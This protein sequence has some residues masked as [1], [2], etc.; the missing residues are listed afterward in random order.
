MAKL[1]DGIKDYWEKQTPEQKRKLSIALVV[2]AVIACSTL[3]Y[4]LSHRKHGEQVVKSN[5]HK[6]EIVLD[7]GMMEESLYA[8]ATKGMDSTKKELEQTTDKVNT[9]DKRI[10]AM[11]SYVKGNAQALPGLAPVAAPGATPGTASGVGPGT[12][13]TGA[14]ASGGSPLAGISGA[15]AIPP[16]P[17]VM[18]KSS[19]KSSGRKS[20]GDFIAPSRAS[21]REDAPADYKPQ[22]SIV[23][24]IAM[25]SNSGFKPEED[26]DAK[27]NSAEA[28]V[29]LPPSFMRCSTLSGIDAPAMGDGKKDPLPIILRVKSPAFLPSGVKANLRGCYLLGECEGNLADERVHVRLTTLSCLSKDGQAVIDQKVTGFIIDE[30]GRVGMRGEVV[31]KMGSS[32][33]RSALAGLFGG[34]GEAMNQ[35]AFTSTTT[36]AGTV[37]QVLTDTDIKTMARAGVGKG[38]STA[39]KDIQQ[40]YMKLAE[41]TVPCISVGSAK[42]VTAV[43]KEGL[44]LNIMNKSMDVSKGLES[45]SGEMMNPV[46]KKG[47]ASSGLSASKNKELGPNAPKEEVN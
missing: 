46:K 36:E 20:F 12:S 2:I 28:A 31:S 13:P 44:T 5:E 47:Q 37:Q 42:P 1:T 30:S 9:L 23:G 32:I 40:F 34:I 7:Q 26:D 33:A 16:P 15:G 43:I 38:I 45:N 6:K 19:E 27:K 41:Q 3:G 22:P 25:G 8:Q 18:P 29:Y 11:E 4:M 24:N 14:P 21:E 39:A 10:S 35:S 17:M